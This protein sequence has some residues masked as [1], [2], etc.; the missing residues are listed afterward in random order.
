MRAARSL[1]LLSFLLALALAAACGASEA[2]EG[3]LELGTGEWQYEPIADGQDVTMVHGAQ[4]GW[5]VWASFLVE[6]LDPSRV[7]MTIETQ[8]ADESEPPETSRVHVDL[9]TGT[10]GAYELVGWPAILARPACAVDRLM[11]VRVTLK[12]RHGVTAGDECYLVPR[13]PATDSPGTCE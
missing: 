1:S 11:R 8:P 5:H 4:G 9:Q 2:G 6:G 12:D 3:T 10:G 13:A 7:E